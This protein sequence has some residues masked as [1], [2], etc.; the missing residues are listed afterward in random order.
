MKRRLT[1]FAVFLRRGAIVNVAV[2][3]ASGSNIRPTPRR[4]VCQQAGIAASGLCVAEGPG[5]SVPRFDR[6]LRQISADMQ[7]DVKS[8][9]ASTVDGL[10]WSDEPPIGTLDWRAC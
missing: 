8:G 3:W 7:V 1:M 6:L 9:D 10:S 2:A 5:S 4:G